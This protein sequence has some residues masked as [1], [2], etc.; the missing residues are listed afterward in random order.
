M[1]L[2]RIYIDYD[3]YKVQ[4]LHIVNDSYSKYLEVIPVR[5]TTSANTND[6]LKMFFTPTRLPEKIVSDN[7]QQFS[8]I[9]FRIISMKHTYH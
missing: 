6:K 2:K 1:P 3:E 5:S 4:Y 8:S 9:E 7:R